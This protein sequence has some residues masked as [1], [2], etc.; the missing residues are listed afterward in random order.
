ML[1]SFDD[2]INKNALLLSK[3]LSI[4]HLKLFLTFPVVSLPGFLISCRTKF[5]DENKY[6]YPCTVSPK[7]IYNLYVMQSTD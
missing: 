1:V 6:Y 2:I 7:N 5:I 3:N 4:V